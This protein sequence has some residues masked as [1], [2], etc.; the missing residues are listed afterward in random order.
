MLKVMFSDVFDCT[1][2]D[3]EEFDKT[4]PFKEKLVTK[5]QEEFEIASNMLDE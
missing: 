4:F 1:D 5:S 2:E 3:V